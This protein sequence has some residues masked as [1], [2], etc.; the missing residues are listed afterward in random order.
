MLRMMSLVGTIEAPQIATEAVSDE[1]RKQASARQGEIQTNI[2]ERNANFFAATD[3]LDGWADDLKLGLER[4]IKEL[5]R[6]IKETRRASTT[7]LT[8]EDKLAGQ[9][10]MKTIESLRNQKRRSLFDAQDA[11]DKQRDE[12]IAK[13]EFKLSQRTELT[14]LFTIRW[15]LA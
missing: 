5:D 1:L 3:K 9:K 7:A 8:L 2:S 4:E 14:T 15:E 6:Q 11:V 13:I 10:Q 12:L